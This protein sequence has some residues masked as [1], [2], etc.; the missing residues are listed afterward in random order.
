M[1]IGCNSVPGNLREVEQVEVR[2]VTADDFIT[3]E[4]IARVMLLDVAFSDARAM[5]QA[6]FWEAFYGKGGMLEGAML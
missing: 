4:E 2:R 3:C 6:E 1:S 5:Q